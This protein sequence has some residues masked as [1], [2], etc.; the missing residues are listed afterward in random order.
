VS[1]YLVVG[2]VGLT[3]T[4]FVARSG[5][6]LLPNRVKLPATVQQALRF[7]PACALAAIIAPTLFTVDGTPSASWTDY[8]LYGTVAATLVFVRWRNMIAAI[9]VGMAVFTVLRVVYA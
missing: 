3:L 5:F 1:A 2:L 7:A 9:C 8:R 6:W 4:T